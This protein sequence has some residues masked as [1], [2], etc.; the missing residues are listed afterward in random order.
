MLL[1]PSA[2][3]GCGDDV[4]LGKKKQLSSLLLPHSARWNGREDVRRGSFW[5]PEIE[6]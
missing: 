3:G 5:N 1:R 2:N 4:G 6:G